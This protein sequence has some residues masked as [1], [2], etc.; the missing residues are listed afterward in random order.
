[1]RNI[2]FNFLVEKTIQLNEM[3]R[4][5]TS[6]GETD[7]NVLKFVGM[8]NEIAK[9]LFDGWKPP[10]IPM[11]FYEFITTS[12]YEEIEKIK[13]QYNSIVTY[14]KQLRAKSEDMMDNYKDYIMGGSDDSNK[15]AAWV[16]SIWMNRKPELLVSEQF[17]NKITDP[18]YIENW[19]KEFYA[20]KEQKYQAKS[21]MVKVER[22]YGVSAVDFESLKGEVWPII[23][24]IN[25]KSKSLM[26]KGVL[27]SLRRKEQVISGDDSP[28]AQPVGDEMY[29]LD[30]FVNVTFGNIIEDPDIADY[31][32]MNLNELKALYSN[33]EKRLNS[34][35]P[36]SKEKIISNVI[37]K[38]PNQKFKKYLLDEY[39][40]D[41]ESSNVESDVEKM[42][43]PQNKVI[44]DVLDIY[45]PPFLD[46][47][48]SRNIITNDERAIILKWK[49]LLGS[50]TIEKWED[51]GLSKAEQG[52]T[53]RTMRDYDYKKRGEEWEAKK[54]KKASKNQPEQ[55]SEGVMSYFTEQVFKDSFSGD[56]G[57]FVERGFK[58]PVNYNH[59]LEINRE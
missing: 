33:L 51:G 50:A 35:Q 27:A 8:K 48:I 29:D 18:E 20:R 15:I 38:F 7:P 28:Q 58:K 32:K 26:P 2:D 46:T 6:R 42:V 21:H 57:T 5:S 39:E 23:V 14:G 47:L 16:T 1:M 13:F 3:G 54:A 45:T 44:K 41:L 55:M 56:R 34:N 19:K 10:S 30:T 11:A 52:E 25:R 37:N 36:L 22:Q 4:A 40:A 43:E 59:W 24:K 31:Y 17:L 9:K 12:L 49:E 53:V